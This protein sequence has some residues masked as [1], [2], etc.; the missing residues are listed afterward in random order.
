MRA[1]R[2]S[3]DVS[4]TQVLYQ[5]V[6]AYQLTR[7]RTIRN[8]QYINNYRLVVSRRPFSKLP[9]NIILKVF[10]FRDAKHLVE[11]MLRI[12]RL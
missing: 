5:G 2:L 11:K 3:S 12:I 1:A 7:F 4:F 6:S 10:Q 9:Y 8:S